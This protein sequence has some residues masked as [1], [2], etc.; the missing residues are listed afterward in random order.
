[1]EII[2]ADMLRCAIHLTTYRGEGIPATFVKKDLFLMML[3]LKIVTSKIYKKETL[4]DGDIKL[5]FLIG[6]TLQV[7]NTLICLFISSVLAIFVNLLFLKK[8]KEEII[9]FGPFLL[10]GTIITYLLE[11]YKLLIIF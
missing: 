11:F 8:G 6:L 1:M 5:S 3:L 2:R 9:P 10:M 4:G 7:F